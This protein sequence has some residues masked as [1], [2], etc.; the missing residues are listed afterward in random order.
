LIDL[1][2]L[3][4]ALDRRRAGADAVVAWSLHASAA[5]RA[6]LGI[7]DGQAGN[8][9]APFALSESASLHYLLVWGDGRVSRGVW[10]RRQAASEVERA[11]EEA[12]LAAYEDPDAAHVLGPAALPEVEL[13][14]S[15]AAQAARG[16]ASDLGER[17]A[18]VRELVRERRF[19]TWSGSFSA[20]EGRSR[21]VTSAGLDA[22]STGTAAS[23]HV[24]LNG[25]IGDG[26]GARAP[27]AQGEFVTRLSRLAALADAIDRDAAL[28]GAPSDRVLL[29]P[30]VVE[31]YVLETLLS[32]LDG[33]AVA[34]GQ[35]HF[36]RSRFGTDTPVLRE[37][38][39]LRIDPLLPNRL[40]S[41]VFSGEGVPA[42]PSVFVERGRLVSPVLDLKYARRLG[43][44]PTAQPG[45][46]DTLTFAASSAIEVEEAVARA[47]GGVLVPSVL[48]VHTQ[49]A[50]SGDFSLSAPQALRIGASG[51]EGRLR[52]T[53]SG[54]LFDI[55]RQGSLELVRFEGETTPGLLIRCRLEP[56]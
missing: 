24:S 28:G 10:E 29:H 22:S 30:R 43:L 15:R 44:R 51:L 33:A 37:D 48:G 1:A 56:V 19:R 14:S 31:S 12:R 39:D 4:A 53:I 8:A 40:G 47:A 3:L 13:W 7:K 16:D 11:L 25:E 49:D 26:F 55:L 23:W 35:S 2:P 18:A 5:T 9:H 45:A 21:I 17:L 38:L 6:S 27:E 42:A 32:N 52:A 36:E 46:F 41:Y 34:H 20:A 54:N 50:V